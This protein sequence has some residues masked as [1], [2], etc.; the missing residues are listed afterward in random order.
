MFEHIV[1]AAF[2]SATGIP[3]LT[4]DTQPL[5]LTWKFYIL[6]SRQQH[7]RMQTDAD[8]WFKVTIN[9]YQNQNQSFNQTQHKLF[10]EK[11]FCCHGNFD[12]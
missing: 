12:K 8:L 10:M 6:P 1:N 11:C 2:K 3:K 9:W 4:E 5:G 7:P